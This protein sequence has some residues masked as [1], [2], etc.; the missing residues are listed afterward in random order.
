M[1]LKTVLIPRRNQKDLVDVPRDVQRELN[2]V[3][4]ERMDELLPHALLEPPQPEPKPKR[5]SREESC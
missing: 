3:L 1:H 5:R 4:V 2:L